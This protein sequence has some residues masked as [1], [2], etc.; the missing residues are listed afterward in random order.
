MFLKGIRR[1]GK[2]G[3][4]VHV[5]FEIQQRKHSQYR[6]VQIC[7]AQ[8]F[9]ICQDKQQSPYPVRPISVRQWH[10][11]GC[12]CHCTQPERI[13]NGANT[14]WLKCRISALIQR[15]RQKYCISHLVIATVFTQNAPFSG[16]QKKLDN[17]LISSCIAW[18]GLYPCYSMTN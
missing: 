14:M 9:F 16:A 10:S 8:Q 7:T 12:L 1:E 11:F 3:H 5:L 6:P 4:D 13:W 17:W 15:V 2:I 18:C